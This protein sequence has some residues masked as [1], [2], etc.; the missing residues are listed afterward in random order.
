VFYLLDVNALIALADPRSEFHPRFHAW[1][2]R[3]SVP[4]MATSPL[5]ENGFLRIFGHPDYPGG[6]GS[7]DAAQVPLS[8]LRRRPDF[9]FL[10]DDFS[11][12]DAEIG[13]DL[14]HVTSKQLTDVYLLALAARHGGKFATFDGRVPAEKVPNGPNALELIPPE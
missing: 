9:T 7:I 5:T 10:P 6:P 12:V 11:L 4:P 13:L 14:Q 8:L 2:R 1:L 3:K